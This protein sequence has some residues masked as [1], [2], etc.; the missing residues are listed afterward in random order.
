MTRRGDAAEYEIRLSSAFA[1]QAA[2][3]AGVVVVMR[4]ARTSLATAAA[5]AAAATALSAAPVQAEDDILD[6]WRPVY[7][8]CG[9]DHCP[10]IEIE[11]EKP[12]ITLPKPSLPGAPAVPAVG[13]AP[14]VVATSHG[15]V[16][17]NRL[18]LEI[19]CAA[20]ANQAAAVSTVIESCYATNGL[21]A[22]SR[23]L[24][25]P[26]VA[27]AGTG[28]VSLM[29][30]SVCVSAYSIDVNSVRSRTA[31]TCQSS[32]AGGSTAGKVADGAVAAR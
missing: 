20:K 11:K 1:A 24:S 9:H 3:G 22:P 4:L 29:P 26:A 12:P 7:T 30:Y 19:S 31:S 18:V 2:S 21:S 16:T 5:L 15:V 10:E 23:A 6:G 27:T 32:L 17:N 25:G 28:N 8:S 14:T 13:G